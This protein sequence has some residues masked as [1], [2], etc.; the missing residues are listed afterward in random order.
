MFKAINSGFHMIVRLVNAGTQLLLK[1]IAICFYK[2][3][4]MDCFYLHVN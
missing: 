2:I 3:L 4:I 1:H